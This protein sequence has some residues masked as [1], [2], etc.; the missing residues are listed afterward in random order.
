MYNNK[1]VV[2]VRPGVVFSLYHIVPVCIIMKWLYLLGQG[3]VQS[4]MVWI[5][6]KWLY[7]SGHVLCSE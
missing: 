1:M 5:I 3:Q 4:E 6:T 7:L 2:F